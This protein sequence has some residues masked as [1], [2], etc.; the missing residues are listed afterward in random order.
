MWVLYDRFSKKRQNHNPLQALYKKT[1]EDEVKIL[2]FQKGM[3]QPI[4]FEDLE[5]LLDNVSQIDLKSEEPT[6]FIY[7]GGGEFP[8][9]QREQWTD[10]CNLLAI[11]DGVVLGYDRNDVTAKAFEEKGFQV[12]KAK[13]L[14]QRFESNELTPEDVTDT[15]ILLPSV[16]LSRARGGWH[17]MSMPI[18][19]DAI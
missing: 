12:M 4:E 13:E 3:P 1:D 10:S 11:K 5:A 2:Q 8:Y 17:C 19:R 18:L 9:S 7:S 15:L 16:E 6:Q 14:I